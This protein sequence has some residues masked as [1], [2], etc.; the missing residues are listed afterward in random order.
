M[1]LGSCFHGP[2]FAFF[3]SERDH[4]YARRLQDTQDLFPARFGQMIGKETTVPDDQAHSHFL[5]CHNFL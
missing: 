1:R 5:I 2:V 4:F 3:G